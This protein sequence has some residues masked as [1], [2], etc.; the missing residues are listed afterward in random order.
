MNTPRLIYYN[1]AHHFHAKRIDPPASIHKLRWPVDEVVGTGVDLLVLGLGYGDV[2]FHDSKVGRVV[3]QE[4][5][6]WQHIIDWRIVRMVQDARAL[7][8]DQVREVIK[9]G[10]ELCLP[11]FPSLKLQD[12]AEPGGER[13]GWLKW[14][15]GVEVCLGGPEGDRE[16]WAYD[17]TN[18]LVQK[19]KLA[20]IGE[21]LEDYEADGVE[22]DFMF[23]PRYFKKDE[24]E[25]NV[26]MMNRFVAQVRELAEV[27]GREQGRQIPICARVFHRKEENLRIGLDVEAWLRERSIDLVVGQVPGS[28]FETGIVDGRW[29][30]EAANAVGAA[31][32]LRPPRRVYDERTIYPSIE[33]FRALGQTLQWQGFAGMYLG[34]LPWPFGEMEYQVLREVAFPEVVARRD[35]R[36]I[37]APREG[38]E[39]GTTTPERQLPLTLEEGRSAAITILIAD[40]VESARQDNEMREPLLTIRLSNFCVEDEV[41][42]RFNGKILPIEEAEITDERALRIPGQF[43]GPIMAPLGFTAHWFCY[44]LDVGLLRQGENTLEVETKRLT[45]TADWTRCVNGVEIQTRYK[46]F[47]RPQGLGVERIA[48]SG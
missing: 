2:Y 44:R 20:I 4:K 9:R 25:Q 29:L 30:A 24:V 19:D 10:R 23:F 5:A 31:A 8:T 35:K 32:Y 45:R 21:I 22:L 40:D 36:Y 26:P 18:E 48:P 11:V 13:C 46:D 43:P 28:C 17:F 12:V 37:L 39:K 14:E 3:G 16:R 47:V 6:V 38:D 34:Y 1:D 33:M 27:I 42:F 7:G 15:H 41:E